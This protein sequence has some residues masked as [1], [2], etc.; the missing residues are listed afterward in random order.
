MTR[1]HGTARR[2]ATVLLD[3]DHTIF[4]FDA[5]EQAAFAEALAVIGL[6]DPTEQLSH[7]ATYDRLNS[8]L[9]AA[10]ER[11]EIRSNSIRNVRFELLLEELGFDA[12]A[13]VAVTMADVFVHGL[14]AHGDLYPGARQVLDELAERVAVALVSNGLGEV[15]HAR[16]ARLG[17]DELFDAVVVSSEVG[18]SKPHPGIFD[19][20]FDRLDTPPKT[21]AVMV[22]DSLSSDIAG[23]AGYGIDTCWYNPDGRP[24]GGDAPPVTHQID[25][26][27]TLLD[28]I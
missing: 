9:W 4:D 8:A 25:C 27:T 2:Y 15:V 28:L 18:V 23:G 16:L 11:G 20:A 3:L 14:G 7:F 6:H 21:T 1:T 13:A 22:G 17:I 19:V 24:A 5:S 26:L 10:A 12:D